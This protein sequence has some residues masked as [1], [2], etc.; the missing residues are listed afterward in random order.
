MRR[1]EEA[2]FKAI[3]VT[4]DTWVTGWRPRDLSTSNFPQLRG[5]C[6]AIYNSDSVFRARLAQAP[7][8][9]PMAAVAH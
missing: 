3:V 9:N 4:L 1:A 2:G 6:L 7:E 5:N 8:E